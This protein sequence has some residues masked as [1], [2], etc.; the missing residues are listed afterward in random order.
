MNNKKIEM[1]SKKAYRKP[2]M[3]VVFFGLHEPLMVDCESSNDYMCAVLVD[4]KK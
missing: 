2:E 4:S 1:Q 3:E